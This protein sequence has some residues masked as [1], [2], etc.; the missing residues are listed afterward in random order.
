MA[1]TY[2]LPRT[3]MDIPL[4]FSINAFD[5]ESSVPTGTDLKNENLFPATKLRFAAN[6][7]L[8]YGKLEPALLLASR[9]LLGMPQTFSMFIERKKSESGYVEE[10]DIVPR[11]SDYIRGV[12]R[13]FIPDIDIDPDMS[14]R[15]EEYAMTYLQPIGSHDLLLLDYSLVEAIRDPWLADRRKTAALFF[16]AVLICHEMAHILEFRS[17]RGGQLGTSGEAYQSAP[18][19]TCTEVGAAWE[20]KMFGGV[21]RPVCYNEEYLSTILGLSARSS[22]WNDNVM[23]VKNDWVS[24]L[25][26]ESFWVSEP[27]TLRIPYQ[28]VLSISTRCTLS[29]LDKE[30]EETLS[31]PSPLQSP[32]K[33]RRGER[34]EV[35]VGMPPKRSK[36]P[37]ALSSRLYERRTCGGKKV[38]YGEVKLGGDYTIPNQSPSV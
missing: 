33:K 11:D 37:I 16:M 4:S 18:G 27:K 17:I 19:I 10:E 35:R 13:S 31:P 28:P 38:V 36:K 32:T 24:R 30:D 23:A 7:P 26:F 22:S 3:P 15:S 9:M 25:F 14:K 1:G 29:D 2:K 6:S 5:Y 20:R 12:I 21:I 8:M 34:R